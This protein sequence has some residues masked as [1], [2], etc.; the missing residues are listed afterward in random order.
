M[1]LARRIDRRLG[2]DLPHERRRQPRLAELHHGVVQRTV[3]GDERPDADAALRVAFRHRVDQH[4]VLLDPLQMAGRD[5]GRPRIDE[6]AVDFVRKEKKVVALHQI[7]DLHHLAA[8]IEVPRRVVGVADQDA[9]RAV[10]DKLL[11]LLDRRQREA[12][13]DRGGDRPDHGAGRYG[14]SHVVGVGRFGYDDLVARIEA[15]HEGEKHRFGASRRDDDVVGRQ[16]DLV[17]GVILDQLFAQRP[18]AVAGA[19]FQHG[20]VYLLQGVQPHLR[21]GQIGLADVEMIDLHA[22]GLGGLGQR[23]EFSNRR[24]GHFTGPKGNLRH[25]E[26]FSSVTSSTDRMCGKDS[27]FFSGSV[28]SPVQSSIVRD[29]RKRT[30]RRAGI[31]TGAP[32]R[33]LRPIRSG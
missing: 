24:L 20:A 25:S 12:V 27:V 5:I 1:V 13:L 26:R 14:E 31:R 11:E 4:H 8:R 6:F 2:D 28:V 33:G 15:R 23:K 17:L 7:A 21:R 3:L 30:A 9:A 32:V 22:A 29:G 18:V 19:V 16:A 10:V